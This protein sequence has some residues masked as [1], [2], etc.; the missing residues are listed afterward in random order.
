MRATYLKLGKAMEEMKIDLV[1][2]FNLNRA[3]G[4][5][6]NSITITQIDRNMQLEWQQIKMSSIRY[7]E[8]ERERGL[9]L[10]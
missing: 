1:H 4:L 2:F 7:L 10:F 9:G 5:I 6:L 3:E 8:R